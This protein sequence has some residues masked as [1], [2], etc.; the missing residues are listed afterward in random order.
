MRD[1]MRSAFE[2]WDDLVTISD[3]YAT[4]FDPVASLADFESPVS[5][6]DGRE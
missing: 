6:G 2:S 4:G 3:L 5:T 1:T